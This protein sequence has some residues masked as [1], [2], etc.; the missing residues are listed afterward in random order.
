MSVVENPETPGP[1]MRAAPRSVINEV[2]AI[3]DRMSEI[4]YGNDEYILVPVPI[5]HAGARQW[6]SSMRRVDGLELQFGKPGPVA[7][8]KGANR[9]STVCK[10]VQLSTALGLLDK[11]VRGDITINRKH[12][13]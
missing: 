7:R 1:S 10:S 5:D 8:L 9:I 12:L 2:V 3:D 6:I 13:P 11:G 4:R